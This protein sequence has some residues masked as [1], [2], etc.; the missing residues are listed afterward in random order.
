[1][2]FMTNTDSK[3]DFGATRIDALI[4]RGSVGHVWG[5]TD[6]LRDGGMTEFQRSSVQNYGFDLIP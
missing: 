2:V 5:S 3:M 1:V 4:D 6:L